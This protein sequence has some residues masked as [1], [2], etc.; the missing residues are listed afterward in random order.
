MMY[1]NQNHRLDVDE[2]TIDPMWKIK[3]GSGLN[4]EEV[5]SAPG[6]VLPVDEMDDIEPILMQIGQLQ[7]NL[8]DENILE[9]RVNKAT[10]VGDYVGVGQGRNAERVTAEEVKAKQ[11]A[12]GNRLGRYHKHLEETALKELLIKCYEYLKQFVVN[13]ETVRIQKPN[14]TTMED[15]Y[16]YYKV[17]AEELQNEV[18]VIPIG[19]EHIVNTEYE[20]RQHI[21]FYTFVSGNPQLAQFINWKEVVKDLARRLIQDDWTKYVALPEENNTMGVDSATGQSPFEQIGMLGL[22]QQGQGQPGMP[23]EMPM[24]PPEE[25]QVNPSFDQQQVEQLMGNNPMLAQQV[26]N[27]TVVRNRG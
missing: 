2:L 11:D 12:G 14:K 18:D 23:P 3:Q 19:A 7:N 17:G 10:G 13:D 1:I 15:N 24:M 16:E 8:T 25:Q 21:D 27:D 4:P 22:P 6:R 9:E 5:Y 26:V 20:L